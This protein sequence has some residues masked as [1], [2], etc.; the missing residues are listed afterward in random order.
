MKLIEGER[1]ALSGV[2]RTDMG[3]YLCIASN[4]IPPSVSKRYDVQVHCECLISISA[5]TFFRLKSFS[6]EK[7]FCGSES[8]RV[9]ANDKQLPSSMIRDVKDSTGSQI[10]E[11]LNRANRWSLKKNKSF[12]CCVSNSRRS[13]MIN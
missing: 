2:Q 4:G 13:L 7:S 11:L 12:R 6:P 1:L 9:E 10:N 5:K 8:S 3:G